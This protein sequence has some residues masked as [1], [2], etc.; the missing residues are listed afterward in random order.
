M[1]LLTAGAQVI[2]HMIVR[3]FLHTVEGAVGLVWSGAKWV[4]SQTLSAGEPDPEPEQDVGA[5][6]AEVA[7]LRRGLAAI[8]KRIAVRATEWDRGGAQPSA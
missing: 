4:Y 1:V 7:E 5:L 3:G 8:E 6:R 2:E